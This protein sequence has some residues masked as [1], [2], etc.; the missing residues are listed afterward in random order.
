MHFSSSIYLFH[1][2]LFLWSLVCTV[3]LYWLVI[4]M[5]EIHWGKLLH[6][7]L[8]FSRYKD[9]EYSLLYAPVSLPCWL[10]YQI[11]FVYI[12]GMPFSSILQTGL[13]SFLAIEASYSCIF[14]TASCWS[15]GGSPGQGLWVRGKL[16]LSEHNH[17]C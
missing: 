16:P 11:A 6:T 2:S 10:F 5:Q 3:K 8:E 14:I 7:K 13:I 15:D 12:G 17:T 4:Y 1:L 9:F